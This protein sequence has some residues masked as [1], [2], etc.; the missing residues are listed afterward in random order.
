MMFDLEDDRRRS[1]AVPREPLVD[2]RREQPDAGIVLLILLDAVPRRSG[3]LDQ[4]ELAG[5]LGP[6]LE[7]PLHGAQPLLDALRV[8]E[9]IHADA[10]RVVRRQS[11]DA[12]H[13]IATLRHR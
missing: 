11:M 12:P 8:V 9:A 13:R 5:P 4:R 2:A 10:H 1:L 3:D 6:D 7:Q